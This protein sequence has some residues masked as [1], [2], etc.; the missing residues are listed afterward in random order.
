GAGGA[1]GGGTGWWGSVANSQ[2]TESPLGVELRP[3]SGA[4]ELERALVAHSVGP[5]KD[6]V[7]PR[8]QP[9]EDFRFHGLGTAEAERGFHPRE[10][11]RRK[12]RTFFDCKANLVIPVDFVRRRDDEAQVLC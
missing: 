7:L 6:P 4:I 12:G 1:G 5:L 10:R 3:P 2:L 8:R 9:A 11:I